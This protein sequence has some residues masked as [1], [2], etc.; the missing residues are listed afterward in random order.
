ME[1][2]EES[3]NGHGPVQDNSPSRRSEKSVSESLANQMDPEELN[4]ITMSG[5][6]PYLS[7]QGIAFSE[8][9]SSSRRQN[10][11]HAFSK[12]L[13]L[14]SNVSHADVK[15]LMSEIETFGEVP[16][17]RS[18]NS[19]EEGMRGKTSTMPDTEAMKERVRQTIMKSKYDVADYYQRRGIWQLIAKHPIFERLTL[20]M[21]SFNAIWIAVDTDHNKSDVLLQADLVFQLMENL[22]CVFFTFEIV[23]R[24]MAFRRKRNCFKDGWFMFDLFMVVLMVMETWCFNLFVYFYMQGGTLGGLQDMSILRVARLMRLSRICRMAKLLRAMPELAIMLK[25]LIAASRSVFFTLILLG[26]SVFVFAIAFTQVTAPMSIGPTYFATV[27]D[28]AYFLLVHGTLLQSTEYK[29]AELQ[30]QGGAV[31][32][33]MFFGFILFASVLIMNMLIGVL[34]DVVSAVAAVEKEEM[35]VKYVQEK[36]E[37]VMAIID[38]DGGGTISRDEFMLILDHHEATDALQDVGVDVVG[39]IDFADFIFGDSTR[40]Q[41][42]EEDEVELTLPEFMEV[43]LQLRGCNNATVKDIVDLRKF[44]QI[45]MKNTYNHLEDARERISDIEHAISSLTLAFEV[46]LDRQVREA[47]AAGVVVPEKINL[48]QLSPLKRSS[49]LSRASAGMLGEQPGQNGRSS[50]SHSSKEVRESKMTSNGVHAKGDWTSSEEVVRFEAEPLGAESVGPPRTA[51]AKWAGE[52]ENIRIAD[53]RIA[54]GLG[55][56]AARRI[57]EAGLD[58]MLQEATAGSRSRGQGALNPAASSGVKMLHLA[59]VEGVWHNVEMP[60]LVMRVEDP[61]FTELASPTS[62]PNAEALRRSSAAG[63]SF[64]SVNP[65]SGRPPSPGLAPLPAP[66]EPV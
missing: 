8:R 17:K 65:I 58:A 10:M 11:E 39:L 37:K 52:A 63:R 35:L 4:G 48:P 31:P 19:G 47:E 28:S 18:R 3:G 41:D 29:L 60:D 21:I 25:G 46:H 50:T 51:P 13:S 23:A 14:K 30:Y 32:V 42:E 7:E 24:L 26:V 54:D 64:N 34:C 45:S 55:S 20:C 57:F 5:S 56:D 38:E 27:A 6:E 61:A 33:A 22:F 62:P 43:V 49:R 44:L 59:L 40:E 36:L 2:T 15:A 16:H 9:P 66:P 53:R 1:H 12:R